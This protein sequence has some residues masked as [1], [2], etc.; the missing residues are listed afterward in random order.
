MRQMTQKHYDIYVEA[1]PRTSPPNIFVSV[2]P[3]HTF[4]SVARLRFIESVTRL[5]NMGT[6]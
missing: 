3:V 6:E 5:F 1:T 4:P 2:G